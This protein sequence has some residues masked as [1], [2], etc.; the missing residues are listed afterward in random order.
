MG[1]WLF[2]RCR[3]AW[4]DNKGLLSYDNLIKMALQSVPFKC[5]F[6]P[7]DATLLNPPDMPQAIAKLCRKTGQAQ[8]ENQGEFVRSVFES[9]ALKY[10]FIIDMMNAMLPEPIEKLHIV[11]G[12]SQNNMLN[13]FIANALDVHVIAGPKEATAVGNIMVQAIAKGDL[14]SVKEGRELIS[15]SFQL[16]EYIPA[17]Q[18]IWQEQYEKNKV[19]FT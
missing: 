1:M 17:E 3:S 8:P 2:E 7:D 6:N 9:L 19:L 16:K 14:S 12:G 13:Q 11:G 5:I 18:E 10:R 15:A 4:K